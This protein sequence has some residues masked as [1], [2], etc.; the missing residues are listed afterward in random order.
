MNYI[1]DEM[2]EIVSTQTKPLVEIRSEIIP[3]HNEE[4][5]DGW[6]TEAEAVAAFDEQ[7]VGCDL[8]KSYREVVGIPDLRWDQKSRETFRIDRVLVPTPELIDRG[9]TAGEIGVEIKRSGERIGP[10]IAQALDYRRALWQI[11]STHGPRNIRLSYVFIWPCQGSGGNLASIMQQHRVG[12]VHSTKWDRF[13]FLCGE[14]Q[15]LIISYGGNVHM[16]ATALT[17]GIRSGSR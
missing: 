14:S 6:P 5:E 1:F 15:T 4:T 9:W 16:S 3:Y 2:G 10:P 12:T 11:P 7:M 8:F 13:R 17:M